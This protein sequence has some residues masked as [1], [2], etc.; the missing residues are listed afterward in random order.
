MEQVTAQEL[1]DALYLEVCTRAR[2]DGKE[3]PN[4]VEVFK[5]FVQ[6]C[7][8]AIA[9]GEAPPDFLEEV[10]EVNPQKAVEA[11]LAHRLQ[12]REDALRNGY[13]LDLDDLM[14]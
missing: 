10:K 3:L 8:D 4:E 7:K 13:V 6:T 2:R 12:A 9:I 11:E 5:H 1:Y 14:K